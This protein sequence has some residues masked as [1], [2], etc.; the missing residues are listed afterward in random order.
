[1]SLKHRMEVDVQ[2]DGRVLDMTGR[3]VDQ[4]KVP[5]FGPKPLTMIG[6]DPR[7]DLGD[8]DPGT[9]YYKSATDDAEWPTGPDRPYWLDD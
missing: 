6:T 8:I 9:T 2:A 5:D 3:V 7:A 1:M 4:V